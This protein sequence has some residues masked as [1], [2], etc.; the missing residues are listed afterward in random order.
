M[1][2]LTDLLPVPPEFSMSERLYRPQ[3]LPDAGG[4]L[5]ALQRQARDDIRM[6]EFP[7][8]HFPFRR[9]EGVLEVAIV[10]G[11]QTGLGTSFG[12]LRQGIKNTMIFDRN[13]PGRQGPWRTYAR[14]HLLRTKKDSTGGLE[15]G[16]PSLHF[17]RWSEA[18]YGADYF[19]GIQKIP[20]LVWADYLDWYVET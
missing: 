11:G 13:P 20:R 6:L 19:E 15:W 17:I 12:L 7:K 1:A 16:I 10:G 3:P 8:R 2:K 9:Q 18:R 5:D 4:R 14:N